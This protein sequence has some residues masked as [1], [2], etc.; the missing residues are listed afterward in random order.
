[1]LWL[2]TTIKLI[3]DYSYEAE[4]LGHPRTDFI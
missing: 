2:L 1:M 4:D 3:T